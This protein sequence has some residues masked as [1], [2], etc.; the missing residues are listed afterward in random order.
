MQ[1]KDSAAHFASVISDTR[2]MF[3]KSTT[4]SQGKQTWVRISLLSTN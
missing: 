3:M 2:N 4:D 1:W